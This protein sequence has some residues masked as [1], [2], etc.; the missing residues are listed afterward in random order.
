MADA[1]DTEF[2]DV[3]RLVREPLLSVYVVTY[4]HAPFVA[5]A[6]D[7]ILA[8]RVAFPF[9]LCVGEDGSDDGTR[10][11]CLDYARRHPEHVRVLLRDRADP[12]RAAY[13]APFLHNSA[14]TWRACRGRYVALLEGDDWWTDDT[15]LA[16]QVALLE[17][18]P[19]LA[20]S[21]HLTELRAD[22]AAAPSGVFPPRADR[23]AFTAADVLRGTFHVHTSSMVLRRTEIPWEAYAS[24]PYG[25]LPILVTHLL[26]GGGHF[27]PDVRSVYRVHAGGVHTSLARAEQARRD[28]RMRDLFAQVVPASARDA[29]CEGAVRARLALLEALRDAP[30]DERAACR[31]ETLDAIGALRGVGALARA[32][33]ML[34]ARLA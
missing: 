9:E 26:R 30:A 19:D 5:R 16:R 8:Q 27:D 2:C 31:R 18:R 28:V 17:S 25:D 11:I 12:R 10:E 7:S 29:A 22:E 33:L 15:K 21:A 34:R 20:V 24:A 14:E 6:L 32:R 13:A 4:R 1:R 3:Q 23:G